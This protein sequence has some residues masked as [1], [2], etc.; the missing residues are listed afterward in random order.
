MEVKVVLEDELALKLE[1]AC[2]LRGENIYDVAYDVAVTA[3]A[4]YA[5]DV[6]MGSAKDLRCSLPSSNLASDPAYNVRKE[7]EGWLKNQKTPG[8]RKP[9]KPATIS[10]YV[11]CL[12]NICRKPGFES[13]GLESLFEITDVDEFAEVASK[14]KACPA[15][16]DVNAQSHNIVS[17]ALKKYAEY[18]GSI[19]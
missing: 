7:F 18:L 4:E 11:S 8:R 14:L 15:Y 1:A 16:E 10:S 13:L 19:Q 6:L 2:L 17:G 3:I 5:W 12:N 9:Y